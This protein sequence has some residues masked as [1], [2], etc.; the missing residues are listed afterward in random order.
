MV[1]TARFFLSKI[2][3]STARRDMNPNMLIIST[4]KVMV[5]VYTPTEFKILINLH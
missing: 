5:G 3:P 1:H 4:S 2:S